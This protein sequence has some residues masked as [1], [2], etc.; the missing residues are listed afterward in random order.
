[1]TTYLKPLAVGFLGATL[2]AIIGLFGYTA[3]TDHVYVRALVQIETQR[4]A[5]S[6]R[7]AAPP[8]K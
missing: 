1:M 6:Q 5:A 3:Y 2:A 4:E 7:P 8:S